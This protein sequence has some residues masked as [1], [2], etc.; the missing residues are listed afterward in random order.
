[1][2]RACGF[3]LIELLL[4]ISIIALLIG[5]LLPVL[6]NAMGAGRSTLCMSNLQQQGVAWESA[7]FD[8]KGQIPR[9]AGLDDWVHGRDR[10]WHHLL[11]DYMTPGKISSGN[12]KAEESQIICPELKEDSGGASVGRNWNAY[13]VNVRWRPGSVSGANELQ[14]WYAVRSPSIYPW[15]GDPVYQ[16]H[17]SGSWQTRRRLGHLGI[18]PSFSGPDLV[19]PGWGLGFNHQ[20]AG[21]AVF[22]DAHVETVVESDFEAVNS[23]GVPDWFFNR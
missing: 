3:T 21:Y 16:Q 22:A 17:H 4:V 5:I 6:S 14:S 9:T 13:A 1:M 12:A 23:E 11:A 2:R 10:W 20:D 15:I 19:M 7:M 8:E 18:W